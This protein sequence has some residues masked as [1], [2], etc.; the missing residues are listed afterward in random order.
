MRKL[1][2]A[3]L[4]VL[5]T[6]ILAGGHPVIGTDPFSTAGLRNVDGT[7]NNIT[8]SLIVDQYGEVIN[9]DTFGNSNQPFVY[10]V[11]PIFRDISALVATDNYGQVGSAANPSGNV[12]D[13]SPRI[14]SNLVVDMDA[15]TNPAVALINASATPTTGNPG[16]TAVFA[17]PFNALMTFFGQFFDHGLDFIDKGGAGPIPGLPN[18]G[19]VT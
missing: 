17:T 3:D 1:T 16:S 14:I 19:V 8:H 11:T 18:P 2:T 15:A 12:I 10:F 13:N 9:T 5:Q 7:F 6:A 4:L